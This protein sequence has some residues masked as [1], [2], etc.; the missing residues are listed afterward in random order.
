MSTINTVG[1]VLF[2][3]PP[4]PDGSSQ[5]LEHVDRGIPVDAGV[6]NG[7]TPLETR[8]SF[9][10]DFLVALVKMRL[11]HDTDN[12]ILACAKL[13]SDDLGDLGLISV[14]LEGVA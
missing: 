8:R 2:L 1:G 9:G 4:L 14:I 10:W 12:T 3:R 11:D 6:G 5:V 7:D 13:V